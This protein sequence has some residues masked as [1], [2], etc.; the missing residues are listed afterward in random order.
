MDYAGFRQTSYDQIKDK[1]AAITITRPEHGGTESPITGT[2]SGATAEA[3][4]STYALITDYKDREIDGTNI[5]IGDKLFVSPAL[6]LD[7]VPVA[8]DQITEGSNSWKIINVK[9]IAPG[10]SGNEVLYK[11]QCRK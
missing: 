5:K 8:T 3:D 1:G 4:Y 10:G 7:I 2:S 9:T 11:I 6:N